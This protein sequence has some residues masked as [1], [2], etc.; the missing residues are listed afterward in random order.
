M[1]ILELYSW[2]EFHFLQRIPT[3]SEGHVWEVISPESPW[4]PTPRVPAAGLEGDLAVVTDP[5]Q[6]LARSP[7]IPREGVEERRW[8]QVFPLSKETP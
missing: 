4:Q 7:Q 3:S 6:A 2:V 1:N 5:A 8:K